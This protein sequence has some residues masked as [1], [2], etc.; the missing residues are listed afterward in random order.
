MTIPLTA[1]FVS[2]AQNE[3]Y[4]LTF[5]ERPV[6]LRATS[7]TGAMGIRAELEVVEN[8]EV[9]GYITPYGPDEH[10][11]V[12]ARVFDFVAPVVFRTLDDALREILL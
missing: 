1:E 11:A 8:D 6:T 4:T 5:G 3:P 9:V 7:A 10:G 12:K 2:A